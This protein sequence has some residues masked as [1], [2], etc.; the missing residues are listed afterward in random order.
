[1]TP[2]KVNAN[3]VL[4]TFSMLYCSLSF[5]MNDAVTTFEGRLA[6]FI[7]GGAQPLSEVSRVFFKNRERVAQLENNR[8]LRDKLIQIYLEIGRLYDDSDPKKDLVQLIDRLLTN[9]FATLML[10]DIEKNSL[11]NLNLSGI[12]EET[13]TIPQHSF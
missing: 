9:H 8:P 10:E 2:P 3:E 1:M 6:K 13:F 7:L 12:I 11:Q 4:T 5:S